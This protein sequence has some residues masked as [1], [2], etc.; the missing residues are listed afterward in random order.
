M[1]Q[2][3]RTCDAQLHKPEIVKILY[4]TLRSA[5]SALHF[6]NLV[7][8]LFVYFINSLL[9]L[10]GGSSIR[11]FYEYYSFSRLSIA[12]AAIFD[13]LT[14]K[15]AAISRFAGNKADVLKKR[16]DFLGYLNDTWKYRGTSVRGKSQ[17]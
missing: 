17:R 4:S 5:V 2:A 1:F 16:E 8:N 7:R 9:D 6:D 15:S 12:T 3:R 13:Y 11:S 10:K 14:R